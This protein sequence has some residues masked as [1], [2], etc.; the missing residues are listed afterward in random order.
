MVGS[1]C[2]HFVLDYYG[3][4]FFMMK[5]I[6][7]ARVEFVRLATE[8]KPLNL[9]QGF[10]DFAAPTDVQ[11]GLIEANGHAHLHQYTRSYV[12]HNNNTDTR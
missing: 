10:P 4:V 11:E 1:T 8:N 12:S 9:G 3:L 5:F 2:I 6:F 7:I